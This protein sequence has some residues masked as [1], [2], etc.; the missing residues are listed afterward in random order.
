MLVGH[1][2]DEAEKALEDLAGW[3]PEEHY[4]IA[5]AADVPGLKWLLGSTDKYMQV[6]AAPEDS[7]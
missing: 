6:P 1:A 7:L 3:K 4:P 2:Q 5:S